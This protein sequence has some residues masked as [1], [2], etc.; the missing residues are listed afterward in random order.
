MLI[1]NASNV[2]L[3]S[4]SSRLGALAAVSGVLSEVQ[5]NLPLIQAIVPAHTFS[6]LSIVCAV[7]V[8]I[9]RVIKQASISGA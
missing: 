2:L 6:I 3:N 7:G 8:S 5:T 4:W 9:A 1:D